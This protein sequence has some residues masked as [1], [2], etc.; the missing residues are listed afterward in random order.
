MFHDYKLTLPILIKCPHCLDSVLLG[1]CRPLP[2][3]QSESLP[4]ILRKVH[5]LGFSHPV[6]MPAAF[7]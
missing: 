3:K 7:F 2:E 4:E 6:T 5:R 1:T